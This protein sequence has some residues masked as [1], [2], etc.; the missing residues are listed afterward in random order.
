M[1]ACA[2]GLDRCLA[3]D[4]LHPLRVQLRHRG[5]ARRTHVDQDPRRQG[6]PVLAGLHLREAAATGPVP[7]RR[8]PPGQSA[9]PRGRRQLH[10]HRLGHRD[11]RD[12]GEVGRGAATAR[13]GE[14]LLLRRRRAGQSPRR[15]L[16]A[17]RDGSGRR[18]VPVECAG[19]G[20]DRRVLGRRSP[21]RRAHPRR[22]RARRGLGLPRKEPVDVARLPARPADPARD[23][24]RSEPGDDRDRPASHRDS[25]TGGPSPRGTPRHGRVVPRRPGCGAGAGGPGRLR[26]PAGADDRV[27]GDPRG[28]PRD[29]RR[30]LRRA[31]RRGARG[32]PRGRATHRRGEQRLVLRGPRGAAGSAQH[33]VLVPEQADLAAGRQ[34]REARRHGD[35]HRPGAA[36][37]RRPR[38]GQ[39]QPGPRR[40]DHRGADADE[41][42]RRGDPHRPPGPL[43]GDGHP[44]RQP[45]AL[46]RRHQAFPRRPRATRT[47]RHR[48]RRTDRDRAPVGLR[49]ARRQPVREGRVHLVQLRVPAQRRSTCARR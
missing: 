41:P 30:V 36:G 35:P 44:E 48:R 38:P 29:P 25:G 49:A 20:E 46:G 6:A 28:L 43:P 21:L 40:A 3:A 2:H 32:D 12:R 33:A 5:T 16:H 9:A 39:G 37:A 42:R 7:E 31:L 45:R 26:L 18:E 23:R 8:A 13:R 1:I 10:A 11:R 17:R 14:H 24:P 19:P 34:L 27:P 4:R 15:L 22:L 47:R